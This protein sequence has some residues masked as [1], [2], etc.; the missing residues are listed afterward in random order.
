MHYNILSILRTYFIS[1]QTDTV[2]YIIIMGGLGY[3]LIAKTGSEK[4][5]PSV[6]N[7]FDFKV[8]DIKGNMVSFADY[9]GKTKCFMIV[10][11]A[12]KC[13]FT[14]DHYT[15]LV[16]LYDKYHSRGL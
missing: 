3:K 9:K 12:C 16:E 6:T 10:N 5:T 14:G 8:K 13:G 2:Y 7:F 4:L 15:Q 11:V 1:I